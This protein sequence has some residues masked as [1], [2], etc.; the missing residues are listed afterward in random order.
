MDFR[1][2]ARREGE[3]LDASRGRGT[4]VNRL[5]IVWALRF[6]DSIYFTVRNLNYRSIKIRGA[7]RERRAGNIKTDR[8]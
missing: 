8:S 5:K 2:V 4:S 6:T 1:D 7:V 3:V